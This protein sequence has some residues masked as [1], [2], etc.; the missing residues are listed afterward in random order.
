MKTFKVKTPIKHNGTRYAAGDEIELNEA[1]AKELGSSLVIDPKETPE[2]APRAPKT[3]AEKEAA[4]QAK[5]AR[6]AK[7]KANEEVTAEL[8]AQGKTEGDED[9]DADLDE[10]TVTNVERETTQ[11]DLDLDPSLVEQGVKVGDVR[12]YPVQTEENAGDDL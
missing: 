6:D 11:E 1:E 9:D 10:P 4:K 3:K 5:K 12:E 7:E 2:L 8:A